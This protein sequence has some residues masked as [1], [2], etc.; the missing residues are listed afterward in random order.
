MIT[1]CGM[2]FRYAGLHCVSVTGWAKGASYKPGD[3]ITNEPANHSWNAVHVDGNWYLLDCHWATRHDDSSDV[4]TDFDDYYF[5]TD[6]VEMIYS[7]F[8]E[9]A[10]WQLL[11]SPWTGSKHVQQLVMSFLLLSN[12]YWIASVSKLSF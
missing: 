4:R 11:E 1:D 12:L 9:D 2:S 3:D 7:H 10:A 5:L 8:P 6:P